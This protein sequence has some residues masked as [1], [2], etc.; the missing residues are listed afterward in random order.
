MNRTPKNLSVFQLH[1]WLQADETNPLIIDVRE[2]NEL[3]IASFPFDFLHLPLSKFS[4]WINHWS[5]G[6][7]RTQAVVVICHSGIRSKRFGSW[8]IDNEWAGEVWNLEGGID[9]WSIN[10][11]SSIPRY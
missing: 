8:L 10:I 9:A 4:D 5:E 11:D 6:V 3:K 2:D 1:D 7:V